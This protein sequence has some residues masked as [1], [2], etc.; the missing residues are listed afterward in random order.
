MNFDS[1]PDQFKFWIQALRLSSESDC[2]NNEFFLIRTIQFA[3]AFVKKWDGFKELPKTGSKT[4][5]EAQRG[6]T[7]K[8]MRS[9]KISDTTPESY[10]SSWELVEVLLTGC[11][12]HESFYVRSSG[13][14]CLKIVRCGLS[15]KDIIGSFLTDLLEYETEIRT[16]AE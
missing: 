4:S 1:S 7:R 9:Q 6:K 3:T 16:D 14:D 10:G 12:S 13:L 5:D 15:D 8:S 2:E 11:L